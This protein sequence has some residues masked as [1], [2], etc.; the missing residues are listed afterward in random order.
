MSP[1]LSEGSV[2]TAV[3]HVE[4]LDGSIGRSGSNSLPIEINLNVVDK[5]RVLCVKGCH[6]G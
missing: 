5:I 1:K 4:D 2:R 3:V 6:A